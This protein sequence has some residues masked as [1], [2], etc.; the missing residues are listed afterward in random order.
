MLVAP[1]RAAATESDSLF[2]PHLRRS[3]IRLR[4]EL[5]WGGGVGGGVREGRE[6]RER[7]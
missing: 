6:G 3:G 2:R 5:V 7:V 4:L 1:L